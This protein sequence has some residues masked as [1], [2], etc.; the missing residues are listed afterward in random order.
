MSPGLDA[1]RSAQ[2]PSG[3]PT[4]QAP[5]AAPPFPG[6]GGVDLRA[7]RVLDHPELVAEAER[8]LRCVAELGESWFSDEGAD[9]SADPSP[10]RPAPGRP[11][12]SRPG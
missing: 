11:S 10:S 8:V 2:V 9:A 1:G 12:P 7:L 5:R 6:L 4:P 3:G